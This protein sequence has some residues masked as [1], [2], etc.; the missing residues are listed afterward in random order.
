[1]NSVGVR[2]GVTERVGVRVRVGVAERVEV[3]LGLDVNEAV[4]VTEA[5]GVTVSVGANVADGSA[6]RVIAGTPQRTFARTS[7]EK[8]P[9]KRM[10]K[11]PRIINY[12]CRRTTLL[13]WK[14]PSRHFRNVDS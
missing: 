4:D 14:C 2:E 11:R 3:W 6:V 12:S 1:M 8:I 10:R 9:S 7:K 5:N 13:F